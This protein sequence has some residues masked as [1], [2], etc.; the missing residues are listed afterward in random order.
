MSN[1]L[2]AR[3]GAAGISSQRVTVSGVRFSLWQ[4]WGYALF[5]VN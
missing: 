3:L 1:D 2:I 5:G 4:R